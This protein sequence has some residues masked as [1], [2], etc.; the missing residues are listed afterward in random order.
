MLNKQLPN[1]SIINADVC[2][3]DNVSILHNVLTM[4]YVLKALRGQDV[5]LVINDST[6]QQFDVKTALVKSN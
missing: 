6:S 3:I 4:H 5:G 1:L 2:T